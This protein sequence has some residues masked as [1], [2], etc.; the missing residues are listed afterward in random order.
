MN[1]KL[2]ITLLVVIVFGAGIGLGYILRQEAPAMDMTS[3]P[4]NTADK[5]P[6]YYRNPMNP[7]ITS[8]V[9]A[10]DEMGMDYIPV[11]ADSAANKVAGTVSI[12][13]VTEQSIGVRTAPV[14]RQSISR[15]VRA[16]GRIDYNETTM[17][18]LHPRVDGWV[19]ELLVNKTG[20][21]VNKGDVLLRIY[22]PNLVT[23]EQEYLLT[24]N[25]LAQARK[26]DDAEAIQRAKQ[27]ADAAR[28][29]LVL[30]EVPGDAITSLEKTGKVQRT[31]DI[32]SPYKGVV[33]N[34]GVRQ[35]QY[36]NPG[37]QMFMIADL[38][39]VWVDVDV[40]EH[41]L[42]WIKVGDMADMTLVAAP[43]RR[44]RGNIDFIYPYMESRSR[45]AKVRLEFDNPDDLLKPEMF[46]SVN[47]HASP[48]ADAIVV[49]S[50]AI[51]RSGAND[52]VF[53]ALGGG[54]F[55]P[56][57]VHLGISGDDVTEVLHGVMPGESVVTSAQFL[58]DSESK[59]NEA[60]ARMLAPKHDAPTHDMNS[61]D[62]ESMD[63]IDKNN[64][65]HDMRGMDK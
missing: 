48:H 1:N 33:T 11:Y 7:A 20:Q 12:D 21:Q 14:T 10:K 46:A 51:I 34:I 62:M 50:A 36:V 28:E 17:T 27:I 5:K 64:T 53:I 6:L 65:H 32:V 54:K 30:L 15:N 39:T 55:E 37:M 57:K 60:T 35:G 31:L 52:Q 8:D 23:S 58:I 25:A 43:G 49:P 13:P 38:S 41:D 44:F 45:T 24:L 4:G 2:A 16:P 26:G 56:R 40:Y 22:S 3:K 59:L 47:I 9:P 63:K 18:R 61:M 29:R 19:E 42:P